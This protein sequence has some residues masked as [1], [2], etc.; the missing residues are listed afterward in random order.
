MKYECIMDA[1]W[2]ITHSLTLVSSG[3]EF[4]I[5]GLSHCAGV[6]EKQMK[7][8]IQEILGNNKP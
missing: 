7:S 8:K 6:L 4:D 5:F 1:S 3:S 2:S